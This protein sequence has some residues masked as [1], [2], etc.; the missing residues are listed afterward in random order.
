MS[1]FC[2]PLLL[3]GPALLLAGCSSASDGRVE[4]SGT[5]TLRGVNLDQGMI[6]FVP[7]DEDGTE[8]GAMIRNGEYRLPSSQ[9]LKPG[10]YKVIITSGE[11]GTV[12]E[13]APGDSQKVAKDRIPKEYNTESKETVEITKNGPNRFD[14]KIP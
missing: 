11:P 13:E 9:G 1:R 7:L 8:N 3:A 6:R 14:Y 10:K 12:D 4:V 2:L 5:V